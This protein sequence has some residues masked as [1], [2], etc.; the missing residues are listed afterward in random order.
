MERTPERNVETTS[1]VTTPSVAVGVDTVSIAWRHDLPPA[2]TNQLTSREIDG[3]SF[4]STH[5]GMLLA[6]ERI[7]GLA[8]GLRLGNNQGRGGP[9][10]LWVEGRARREPGALGTAADVQELT[11]NAEDVWR[12]LGCDPHG[13]LLARVRRIDLAADL[14]L[15]PREGAQL[16]ANL[17]RMPL[18]RSQRVRIWREHYVVGDRI[19]GMD[20]LHPSRTRQR[21]ALRA[22][23]KATEQG[24][25]NRPRPDEPGAWI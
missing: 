22:Y 7:N 13:V 14:R 4:R 6:D 18:E 19:S 3:V 23:C 25:V 24:A 11:R 10:T 9:S 15:L 17:A 2:V 1:S 12:S 16:L 8:Y 20:I 21:L 5:A